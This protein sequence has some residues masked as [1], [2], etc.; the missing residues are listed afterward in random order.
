[1]FRVISTFIIILLVS[2]PVSAD[3]K[4]ALNNIAKNE[5]YSKGTVTEL[6]PQP[7]MSKM[8]C[9]EKFSGR[10]VCITVV[11]QQTLGQVAGNNDFECFKEINNLPANVTRETIAPLWKH[12]FTLN[13]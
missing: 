12:Y 7:L 4:S 2:T 10:T 9:A 13:K 3:P 8:D 11:E 6:T 5:S 1:M